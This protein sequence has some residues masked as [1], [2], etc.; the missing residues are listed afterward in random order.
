MRGSKGASMAPAPT[1]SRCPQRSSERPPPLPVAEATTLGRP[2]VASTS[3]TSRPA[4]RAQSATKAA[5]SLS[6]AAP[7]SSEGLIESIATSSLVRSTTSDPLMASAY[8][9]A[10]R[11]GNDVP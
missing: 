9:S 6:P 10:R 1:V 2:G 5:T 8:G 3:S 11:R 7:G 4:S